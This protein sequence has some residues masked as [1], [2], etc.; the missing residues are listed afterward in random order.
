MKIKTL[1]VGNLSYL[2][3]EEQIWTLFSYIGKLKRVIMGIHRYNLTPCGFCFLEFHTHLDTKMSL[4]FLSGYKLDG[5]ILRIDLDP[6]F[7]DGRQYGRG[8]RGGQ[9]EDEFKTSK[10]K[11]L[12]QSGSASE[13]V[14][15][16]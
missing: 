9:M 7:K 15:S 16:E 12:T 8:K 3:K 13:M 11:R 10:K 2:T 1:Y 4:H 14:T 5:R 6:G